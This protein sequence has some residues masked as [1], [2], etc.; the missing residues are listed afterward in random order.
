MCLCCEFS[1]LGGSWGAVLPGM[2]QGPRPVEEVP[3]G[4]SPMVGPERKEVSEGPHADDL[5]LS[6][7]VTRGISCP[8]SL[9]RAGHAALPAAK[10]AGRGIQLGA[11]KRGTKN[12]C[13]QPLIA[14]PCNS[15]MGHSVQV[16]PISSLT[17]RVRPLHPVALRP[18]SSRLP[19]WR[20]PPPPLSL[21]R[22]WSWLIL[23]IPV[24]APTRVSIRLRRPLPGTE[25]GALGTIFPAS[26]PGFAE[27]IFC[28]FLGKGLSGPF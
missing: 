13:S 4:T 17:K 26:Q 6:P 28:S 14:V 19:Y 16:T 18:P 7:E 20:P 8:G 9:G 12:T 15:R 27:R 25:P 11:Q 2:A 21:C 24:T 22:S 23:C 1:A 3:L 5:L 10:G